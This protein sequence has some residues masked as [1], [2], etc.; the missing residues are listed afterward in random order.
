MEW[1]LQQTLSVN[2]IYPQNTKLLFTQ[3]N[4]RET[5]N[6]SVKFRRCNKLVNCNK[7][8]KAY[9]DA[10]ETMSSNIIYK[11]HRKDCEVSY[12]G[13]T[14]RQIK[15]R[16]RKHKNNIRLDETRHLVITDHILKQEHIFDW[17]NIVMSKLQDSLFYGKFGVF[18]GARKNVAATPTFSL[19]QVTLVRALC[20]APDYGSTFDLRML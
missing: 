3:S 9:K 4:I 6:F 16:I 1:R 8:V 15:T 13:Q 19:S 11:I 2:D 18:E 14:K 12:A 17:N 5:S 7:I 20:K 10:T